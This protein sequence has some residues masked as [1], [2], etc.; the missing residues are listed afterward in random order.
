MNIIRYN[1]LVRD[2]IP[3]IIEASGKTCVTEI[4]SDADYL[5]M[6][7]AKLDEELAEYH[8]DQNIEELADLIEVIYDVA[9]ARGYTLEQLESV[10]AEKAAK[11]GSFEK[12]LLLKRVIEPAEAIGIAK[13]ICQVQS[14]IMDKLDAK[15][16]DTYF[17]LQ[18]NL[19]K[20][21]ISTDTEYQR[22]FA[23]YYRMRFVSQKYRSKFFEVFEAVK[24]QTAPSF[25]A[26]SETL[27]HVDGRHEFSFITKM[28]HTIDPHRPIYD[29]QVDA[30]LGIHRT[31]QSN[32]E[33]K[34]R[35]D[36]T[37]LNR[38]STLYQ[39]LAVLPDMAE[40]LTAIDRI[41]PAQRMSV[42]KKLDFILWALGGLLPETQR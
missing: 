41:L 25:R 17:W 12:K 13:T 22:K 1:K 40:P 28:L 39:E 33:K 20:R 14:P 18:N 36:E 38:L 34:L 21:N 2:C 35:Q 6:L 24:S 27:F 42:E 16:F 4:L 29:S 15:M 26:V 23:G 7:D 5:K 30:A 19:Q 32:F 3:E 37:I 11:R 31:Y 10:R 9:R 8:R